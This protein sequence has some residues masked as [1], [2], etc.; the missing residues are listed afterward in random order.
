MKKIL[1]K[2]QMIIF[3]IAIMLIAAGYMSYARNGNKIL[4]LAYDFENEQR[5]LG[6]AALVSSNAVEETTNTIIETSNKE[7]KENTENNEVKQEIEDSNKKEELS[8]VNASVSNE[9]QYFIKSRL[10]REKMYSQMLESYEKILTNNQIS[11]EQK[12]ISQKEIKKI[13][14]IKNALM[15]TE[16]LIK[17]KGFEDLIIFKNGESVNAIIKAKKLEDEQIAKI[18]NIVARE[19]NTSIENIHITN[20]E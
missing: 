12:E 19:L 11:K 6:D 9:N 7:I 14:D 15:I 3:V 20:K 18:Q 1:K 17:N 8:Q 4:E 2:N 10:D 5:E 13:N 16:N